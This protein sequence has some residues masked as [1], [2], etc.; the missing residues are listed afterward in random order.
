[1]DAHNILQRRAKQS[2]WIRISQIRL[3]DKRQLG[4]ILNTVDIVR[5]YALLLHEPSVIRN[6]IPNM[7]NLLR[8][9]AA[10]EIADLL[11]RH[12]FKFRLIIT[13]G[14]NHRVHLLLSDSRILSA[15]F[16]QCEGP[17]VQF[18]ELRRDAGLN[19]LLPDV[20]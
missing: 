13:L 4:D 11:R 16:S 9:K 10:L 12:G 14:G 8:Q 20:V 15:F 2:V 7:A 3:R 1:M 19:G 18:K 17:A 6:M 5:A